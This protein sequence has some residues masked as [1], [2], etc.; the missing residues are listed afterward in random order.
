MLRSSAALLLALV[1]TP[2]ASAELFLPAVFGDGMVLQRDRPVA[3][4]GKA[5]PGADVKA[6]FAGGVAQGR[7]DD[8]GRF[9]LELP[10]LEAS[11]EP[12]TLTVTSGGETKTFGDVLVGEVWVCSGQSN[13]QWS[14]NSALSA[15]IEAASANYPNLRLFQIP[16][17]TSAEPAE[18]VDASWKAASPQTVPGFSAVGYYFARTM[19]QTLGVPVGMI[20]TA[21]GGTRAE[22]WTPKEALAAEPELEPILSTWDER[23]A[24]YDGAAAMAKFQQQKAAYAKKL[25][26]WKRKAKEDRVAAGRPPRAPQKPSDP[27]TDRHRYSTLYNKMVHPIVPYGIRGAIWYQGESNSGRAVQYRTLMATLIQSWRDAWGYDFPFYQV[28]L[29]NFKATSDQPQESDW[30]ELRE[31]QAIAAERVGNADVAVITDIGAA[32]DIH[33]KNKQDVAK[34]LARLALTDVH[35]MKMTRKGPT[36]KDVSYDGGKATLTFDNIG[37]GGLR[38]LVTYYNEPLTGFAITGE[39][40]VWRWADAKVTKADTVVLSHPEVKE[41]VA[42]RYNWADNPQGTLFNKAYLPAAPFRTDDF[43]EVTKDNVKP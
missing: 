22:A 8:D 43:P 19:H 27:N 12:R 9:R 42:V 15:E 17:V 24:A 4:F 2:A 36:L 34:R 28:Q 21:W 20:Q 7:A 5:D 30:A 16:L 1:F 14:V 31:A 29:A 3:V 37:E 10:K 6:D 13:M 33:P 39:D 18:D 23:I 40:R 11:A 32:K 41:P 38:G 26:A 25:E 35:G